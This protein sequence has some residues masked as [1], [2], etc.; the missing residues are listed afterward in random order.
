MNAN[1]VLGGLFA[2]CLFFLIVSVKRG[3]RSKHR[4]DEMERELNEL[5]DV[6]QIREE[7][8]EKPVDDALADDW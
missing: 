5:K 2:L 1:L 4:A 7:V 3:E 6:K 8:G